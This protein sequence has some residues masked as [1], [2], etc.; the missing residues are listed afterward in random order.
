MPRA[1][2]FTLGCKLNQFETNYMAHVLKNM[3]YH[4]VEFPLKAEVYVIN[5]CAVTAKSERHSRYAVRRAIKGNSNGIVIVSGCASQANPQAF[6]CIKGVNMIIGNRG[7]GDIGRFL[8]DIDKLK[9]IPGI[10]I[11]DF[12]E[13][14]EP[15]LAPM[16][17]ENFSDYTRAFIKVQ[18]GCSSCCTY[19]I[20][21]KVR[22][23]ARS[24]PLSSV[25]T[26]AGILWDMGYKEIVLTGIHLGQYGSDIGEEC[27]LIDLLFRLL[28]NTGHNRLRLSSMEPNEF[29]QEILDCIE[30]D[31]RICPHLHIP[32]QSGSGK[33]LNMMG[34]RYTPRFYA[35]LIEALLK[36]RPL[37]AIGA[38]VMVGFPGET[39]EDFDATCRLVNALPLAYLHVFSF[40]P[41]P[42]TVAKG[43]PGQVDEN[44][45]GERSKL[46]RIISQKK[47]IAFRKRCLNT[48]LEALILNKSG[49][50]PG[51][52]IALTGNYI[53]VIVKAGG[54]MVNKLCFVSIERL[55]GNNAWGRV[56]SLLP[57]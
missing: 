12:N 3:G 18:D 25:I 16:Q 35:E 20:V 26:Q 57:S 2:L 46:L 51:T 44:K 13:G 47:R 32:L 7:K 40:S 41:R 29:T 11:D 42:G 38:D 14:V 15:A 19:C 54:S 1:A 49:P 24:L 8:K 48:E 39:Q 56:T 36:R 55:E 21:P 6:A 4:I 28:E 22:G 37:L 27:G 34:R 52:K 43:L 30:C 5:T 45:K 23:P 33:I 10:E 9:D 50:T 31:D 53:P 17:I